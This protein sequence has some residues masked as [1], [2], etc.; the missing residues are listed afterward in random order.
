[1]TTDTPPVLAE[2]DAAALHMARTY[3]NTDPPTPDQVKRWT[4]RIRKWA[5]RY[6]NEITDHGRAG[7]LRRYDLNE[8]HQVAERMISTTPDG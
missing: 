5:S 3:S 2:I 1:M 6:P 7:R 8:L 4:A